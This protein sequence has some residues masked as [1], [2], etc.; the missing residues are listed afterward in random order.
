[1]RVAILA[2]GMGTRLREETE[3]RPKTM[4]EIGGRPILWHIM[5]IYAHFGYTDF[6]VCLGYKGQVIRDYFLNYQTQNCDFT[7]TLGSGGDRD[8]QQS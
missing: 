2:G 8:P 3:Y 5:K 7:V 1:M 4:V 6:V